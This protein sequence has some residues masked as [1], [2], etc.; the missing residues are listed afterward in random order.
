[1][2]LIIGDRCRL[3]KRS[4]QEGFEIFLIQADG[5][6]RFAPIVVFALRIDLVGVAQ[7][8]HESLRGKEGGEKFGTIIRNYLQG[9]KNK[10]IY[11]SFGKVD[12]QTSIQYY[13]IRDTSHC[14]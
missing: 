5:V 2:V 1:M 4:I 12:I 9:I 7:Q 3:I 13:R 10:R 14:T 8:L 6:I 11:K